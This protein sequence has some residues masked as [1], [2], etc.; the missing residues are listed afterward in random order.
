MKQSHSRP[1]ASV[2]GSSILRRLRWPDWA[3]IGGVAIDASSCRAL[4]VAVD[5]LCRKA[6]S[7]NDEVFANAALRE[8][9]KLAMASVQFERAAKDGDRVGCREAYNSLQTVAHEAF[10][11]MHQM[12]FAPIGALEDVSTLLRVSNLAQ[13][14]CPDEAWLRIA[15][16]PM[17]CFL[18]QN[19][20][21]MQNP[22]MKA[23]AT[24][25]ALLSGAD[26]GRLFQSLR[27]FIETR[28]ERT[29]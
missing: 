18:S 23:M 13:N 26:A 29:S 3:R 22:A 11:N 21:P 19:N 27:A 1:P 5:D 16:L 12:S 15:S 20:Q 8:L 14:G 28:R 25:L 10:T 24:I 6:A 2:M 4:E 7:T 9:H 17:L